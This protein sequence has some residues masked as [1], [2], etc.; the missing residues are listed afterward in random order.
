[1]SAETCREA[2]RRALELYD[3]G[4][5]DVVLLIDGEEAVIFA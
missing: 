5:Q 2:W 4:Q 1:M 3:G